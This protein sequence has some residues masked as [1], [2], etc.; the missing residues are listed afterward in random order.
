MVSGSDV[1]FD[2]IL[3]RDPAAG[4]FRDGDGIGRHVNGKMHAPPDVRLRGQGTNGAR[5]LCLKGNGA[6]FAPLEIMNFRSSRCFLAK[7]RG[8]RLRSFSSLMLRS[9]AR[10]YFMTSMD[11]PSAA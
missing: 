1:L 7:K 2:H 5:T 11:P 8:V 9:L 3:D 4:V 6:Y 10:R